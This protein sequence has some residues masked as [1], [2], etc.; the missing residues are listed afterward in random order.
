MT[1]KLRLSESNYWTDQFS[2]ACSRREFWKVVKKL[3]RKQKDN[4]IGSLRDDDQNMVLDDELKADL[5]N[6]Y[7]VQVGKNPSNA[8]NTVFDKGVMSYI[9][10]VTPT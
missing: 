5:M 2:D 9:S 3:Q 4:R 8:L 7:V 6:S 10:R 1:A